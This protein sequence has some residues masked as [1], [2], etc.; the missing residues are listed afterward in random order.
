[1]Y[2]SRYGYYADEGMAT[3]LVLLILVCAVLAFVA[4][5]RMFKKAGLPWERMF[6]P[7]YGNYWMYGIADC[8]GLFWC[9]LL[10]S[11]LYLVIS[12]FLDY[13]AAGTFSFIY[14]IVLLI[15]QI[16]YCNK[17]AKA[18]GKGTGFTI[19]LVLLHPIFI[20]ILGFGSAEHADGENHEVTV[21]R[22]WTCSC[23]TENPIY[24]GTCEN[25][26]AKK[27]Y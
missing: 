13:R 10:V 22:S 20:M 26:G 9:N 17:L 1:M 11:V 21:T 25:C 18:F 4:W 27:K 15:L 7:L 2:R 24:K 23:G 3:V 5:C 8:G 14:L 19:G 6:V 16:V 12:S